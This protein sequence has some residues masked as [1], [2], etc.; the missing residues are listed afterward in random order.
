MA[1]CVASAASVACVHGQDRDPRELPLVGHEVSEL[2]ECP[3]GM[4][5]P[6]LLPNSDPGADVIQVFQPDAAPGVFGRLDEGL[7]DNVVLVLPEVRFLASELL[8]SPLGTLGAGRLEC[9]SRFIE[10]AA[11]PLDVIAAE[12]VSV[13]VGSDVDDTEVD[14]N[15]VFHLDRRTFGD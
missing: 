2:G 14:T 5:R 1:A 10:T 4:L 15:K 8:Q 9:P 13:A 11:N 7:A 12:G 3:T 6:V